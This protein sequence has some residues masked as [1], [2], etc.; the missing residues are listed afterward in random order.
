MASNSR[1]GYD[2]EFIC[3]AVELVRTSDKPLQTVARE[4]GVPWKTLRNWKNR[5]S[6]AQQSTLSSSSSCAEQ[7]Q[8]ENLELRQRL[9]QAER[10]RD[11]LKK[12]LAICSQDPELK[13][14][15]R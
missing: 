8:K 7:L 15:S 3:N 13:S 6:G 12:A 1:R 11:I 5:A 9:A 10:Q 4:L 2:D 14:S